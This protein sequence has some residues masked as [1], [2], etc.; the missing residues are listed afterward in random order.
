MSNLTLRFAS[1]DIKTSM[2][3]AKLMNIMVNIGTPYVSNLDW[4]YVTS[5]GISEYQMSMNC[6]NHR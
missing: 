3:S 4:K 5:S 2:G 1:L 6:E